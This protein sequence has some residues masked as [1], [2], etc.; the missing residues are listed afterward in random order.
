M[1]DRI[2]TIVHN[3]ATTDLQ[4]DFKRDMKATRIAA[5]KKA[6]EGENK[7]VNWCCWLKNT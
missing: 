1:A 2:F 4:A 3:T 5:I 7:V 6:D